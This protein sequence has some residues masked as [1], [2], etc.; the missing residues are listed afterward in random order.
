MANEQLNELAADL[1]GTLFAKPKQKRMRPLIKQ[2][3]HRGVTKKWI[4]NGGGDFQFVGGKGY[5][6]SLAARDGESIVDFVKR[7]IDEEIDNAGR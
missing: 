1:M 2:T 5:D 6:L 3:T 7:K 4:Y